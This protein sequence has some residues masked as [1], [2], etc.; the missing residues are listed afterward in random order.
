MHLEFVV[1]LSFSNRDIDAWNKL[2]NH[3][4]SCETMKSFKMRF[5]KFMGEDGR[6]N[7]A[8]VLTQGLPYSK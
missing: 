1:E 7:Q 5:D 3:I 4:V 2:S 6:W 8:A